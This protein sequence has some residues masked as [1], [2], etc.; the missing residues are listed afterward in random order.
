[1]VD[2]LREVA[3]PVEHP[4]RPRSSSRRRS[5]C[6][7]EGVTDQ[8]GLRGALS[9]GTAAER[10]I[11]VRIQVDAGLLH[12]LQSTTYHLSPVQNSP[13]RAARVGDEV[14]QRL[15]DD[16]EEDLGRSREYGSARPV[17]L[18]GQ[19]VWAEVD[20]A[21]ALHRAVL[22]GVESEP[23]NGVLLGVDDQHLVDVVGGVERQLLPRLIARVRA[24]PSNTT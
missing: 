3:G 24:R 6:V 18:L 2:V 17:N 7:R 11:D 23:V 14:E 4:A 16:S 13:E 20:Q 8:R 1:M 9:G 21:A 19:L 12:R 10:S 22:A 5:G 15:G